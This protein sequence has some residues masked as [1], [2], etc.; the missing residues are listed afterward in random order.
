M[1]E[2]TIEAI[3]EH[4]SMMGMKAV[5]YDSNCLLLNEVHSPILICAVYCIELVTLSIEGIIIAIGLVVRV[6]D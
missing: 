4:L 5:S 1:I 6:I 3:I 2:L